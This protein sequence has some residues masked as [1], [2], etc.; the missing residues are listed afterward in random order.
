[1]KA[2]F[3]SFLYVLTV[4]FSGMLLFLYVSGCVSSDINADNTKIVENNL[5]P[6]LDERE[7]KLLSFI[8]GEATP[9]NNIKIGDILIDRKNREVSF[10]ATINMTSGQLECLICTNVG[11][12]HESLLLSDV[13]PFKLQLALLLYGGENGFRKAESPETPQGTIFDID[14]KPENGERVPVEKWLLNTQTKKEYE[15]EGWVFVGSSFHSDGTCVADEEGNLVLTWSFGN[16]IL[17]NP[18]VYGDTDNCVDIYSENVPE[19]GTPV[20]VYLRKR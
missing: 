10:P 4:F 18:S 9:D 5:P 6:P 20:T 8:G 13:Q 7:L 3:Q 2:F 1:M 19:F 12:R 11:R 15:R 17:D 16:T 14:V